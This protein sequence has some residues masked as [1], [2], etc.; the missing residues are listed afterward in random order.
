MEIHVTTI[1]YNKYDGMSDS[2][3]INWLYNADVLREYNV[4]TH[5]QIS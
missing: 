3:K 2:P 4:W 1:Y 5:I